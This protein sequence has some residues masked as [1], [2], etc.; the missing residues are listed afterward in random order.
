MAARLAYL[1]LTPWGSERQVW[2]PKRPSSLHI[3][4]QIAASVVLFPES[5]RLSLSTTCPLLPDDAFIDYGRENPKPAAHQSS[6]GAP[7]PKEVMQRQLAQVQRLPTFKPNLVDSLHI[8]YRIRGCDQ[9]TISPRN[10]PAN[11]CR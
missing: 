8:A 7:T 9:P 6:N 10:L 5:G 4:C 2:A 3:D 1:P 11:P